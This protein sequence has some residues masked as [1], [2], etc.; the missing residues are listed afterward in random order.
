M[1]GHTLKFQS[2][3][4]FVF[5]HFRYAVRNRNICYNN[6]QTVQCEEFFTKIPVYCYKAKARAVQHTTGPRPRSILEGCGRKVIWHKVLGW[7]I[8]FSR[9]HLRGCCK[10]YSERREWKTS[11][12]QPGA[13]KNL[14]LASLFLILAHSG[15][16]RKR[17]IKPGVAS[18]S[19]MVSKE[20]L[21]KFQECHFTAGCI[22]ILPYTQPAVSQY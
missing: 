4:V 7:D 5:T 12:N 8:G 11:S 2:D 18:S 3:Y 21:C 16:P 13:I 19:L 15:H 22:P 1:S 20:H 10:S 14:E 9:C 6:S 17:V